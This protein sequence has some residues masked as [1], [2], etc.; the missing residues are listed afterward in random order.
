MSLLN[1][2][3]WSMG[4]ADHIQ[5][6]KTMASVRVCKAVREKLHKTTVISTFLARQGSH[7]RETTIVS[8]L[9]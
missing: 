3:N 8:I 1:G 9:L 6:V 7:Y 4:D 2:Y 5:S